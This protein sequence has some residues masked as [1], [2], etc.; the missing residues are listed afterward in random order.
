MQAFFFLNTRYYNPIQE[1]C[2]VPKAFD[3]FCF[4]PSSFVF[5]LSPCSY[6]L[7]YSLNMAGAYGSYTLHKYCDGMGLGERENGYFATKKMCYN[8]F[9]L[10]NSSLQS[11]WYRQNTNKSRGQMEN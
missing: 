1:H 9:R 4:F 11:V 10:I 5:L 7:K 8:T 3:K 2:S 6:F